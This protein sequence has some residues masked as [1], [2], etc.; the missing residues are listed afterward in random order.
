ME[1]KLETKSAFAARLGVSKAR[2]SQW[3]TEGKIGPDEMDGEGRSAMIKVDQAIAKLKLRIDPGQRVGNGIATRLAPATAEAPTTEGDHLDLRL[4]HAR[5]QAAEAQNRKLQE[6]EKYR[7]GIYVL[8]GDASAEATHIAVNIIQAFEGGLP[9]LASEI[10]SK[11]HLSER[12]LLHLMR[13]SAR[14]LRRKIADSLKNQAAGLPELVEE[15]EAEKEIEHE[16]YKN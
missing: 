11:Y 5:L 2:V 1:T 9:G 4:K 8:A 3:I 15:P 13:K 6:D 16:R 10:A 12:D 14:E 7:K